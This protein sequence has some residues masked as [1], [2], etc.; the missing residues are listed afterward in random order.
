MVIL[1]IAKFFERNI[2]SVVTVGYRD[3]N[4]A[5]LSSVIWSTLLW[6]LCV[7][8]VDIIFSSCSFFF[9]SFYLFS[10][11]IL[12]RRRLGLPYFYTWCGLS[13]NLECRCE[14][15]CTRLSENT[16]RKNRQKFDILAPSHNFIGLYLRNQGMEKSC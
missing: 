16:W 11:S 6:P 12:S 7:A 14:M 3:N 10:S 15:C 9:L 2:S 8:D 5:Q 13:A 1:P 4:F